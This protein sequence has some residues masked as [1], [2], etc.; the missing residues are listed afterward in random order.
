MRILPTLGA[1]S[2]A[3]TVALAAGQAVADTC[4][5]G[6]ETTKITVMADWIPWAN[7]GPMFTATNKGYYAD[8]G[9]EVEVISPANPA[10]PIKLVA[11][12][13]VHLSMTYVPEVMISQD[14]GIPVKSMAVALRV[15]SSGLTVMPDQGVETVADL[16]GKIL[17]VGPKA[18]AQAFLNTIL[19]KAGLT[20]KDVQV[21]DP[22]FGHINYLLTGKVVAAHSLKYA[23][24]MI[25]EEIHAK[26]NKP[27]PIFF[28]YNDHGVP[29]MYYQLYVGNGDWAESNPGTM[30]RFLRATAKG[31]ETYFNTDYHEEMNKWI[32][33]KNEIFTLDQHA[34]MMRGIT[35]HWKDADGKYWVQK[36][37]SWKEAQ[38]WAL[39]EKLISVPPPASD[40]FTN[41]YV[42]DS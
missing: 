9:I 32:F 8:E 36:E 28:A 19:T 23:E 42:P 3:A 39:R 2:V 13:R 41:A 30:C 6:P 15:L 24:H 1:V 18:D 31:A 14:T 20:K 33:S 26:E 11:R 25:I 16:K 17:G 40:Y 4:S 7:Q 12:Q 38:E 29:K 35:T 10:D 5:Q 21:V 34:G 22:G 27:D 37:D